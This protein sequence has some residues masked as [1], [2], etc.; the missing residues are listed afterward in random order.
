MHTGLKKGKI[1]H[2]DRKQATGH[3][4]LLS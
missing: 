2:R 3:I 1:G 4:I